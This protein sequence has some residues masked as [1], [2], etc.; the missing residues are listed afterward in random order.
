MCL[1]K[2]VADSQQPHSSDLYVKYFV[3]NMVI[4]ILAKKNTEPPSKP[5]KK[6]AASDS[7]S[8]SSGSASESGLSSDEEEQALPVVS[9]SL[10]HLIHASRVHPSNK[11]VY[12]LWLTILCVCTAPCKTPCSYQINVVTINPP[13][14]MKGRCNGFG[15]S[16]SWAT[17][18]LV[19]PCCTSG[20]F[21]VKF[22]VLHYD[23]LVC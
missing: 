10:D 2:I 21:L 12:Q 7:E 16:R 18:D 8:S 14:I 13:I 17:P 1:A 15:L 3:N 22:I 9:A 19:I 23:S 11:S 20:N 5:F 4:P 6:P